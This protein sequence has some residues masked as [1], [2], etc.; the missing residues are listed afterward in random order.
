MR[1]VPTGFLECNTNNND[2]Y[3]YYNKNIKR[4]CLWSSTNFK[5]AESKFEIVGLKTIDLLNI[6]IL[7]GVLP[8]KAMVLTSHFIE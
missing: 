2:N 4:Q 1:N 8:T 3:Y 5:S 7:R 6:V